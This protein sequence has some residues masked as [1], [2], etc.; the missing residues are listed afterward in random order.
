MILLNFIFLPNIPQFY[1]VILFLQ[2]T[3]NHAEFSAFLPDRIMQKSDLLIS[4]F[5]VSSGTLNFKYT[6][7]RLHCQLHLIHFHEDSTAKKFRDFFE[8]IIIK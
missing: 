5:K 1:A 8:K 3:R 7:F 4:N 6:I 2:I